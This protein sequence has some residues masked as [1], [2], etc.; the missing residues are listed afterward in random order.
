MCVIKNFFHLVINCIF[1]HIFKRRRNKARH[2]EKIVEF[3][4]KKSF[5]I[6]AMPLQTSSH[7]FSVIFLKSSIPKK[8]KFTA[9]CGKKLF[10]SSFCIF[11]C[12]TF[13]SQYMNFQ[14]LRDI[15]RNTHRNS[16]CLLLWNFV[17]QPNAGILGS[18]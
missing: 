6:L 16:C 18:H 7:R 17:I 3:A 2:E 11:F 8:I 15:K 5:I 4:K 12:L 1:K 13:S 10:C 14:S 9:F